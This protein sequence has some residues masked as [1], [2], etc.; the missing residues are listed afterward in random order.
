MLTAIVVMVATLGVALAVIIM[1]HQ[2]YNS[3]EEDEI[4]ARFEEESKK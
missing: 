3:I 1:I 2:E 4:T